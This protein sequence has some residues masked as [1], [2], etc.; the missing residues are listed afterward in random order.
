VPDGQRMTCAACGYVAYANPVPSVCAIVTDGRGRVLLARR[1]EEPARGAW[2]LPGGF[3]EEGEAPLEA[4][5]RELREETGLEVEVGSLVGVW[6]DWYGS[7]PGSHA[8][9]NLYWTARVAGGE[10]RPADDV[11]ELRW[12]DAGALPPDDELA[13]PN[14]AEALR[15]WARAGRVS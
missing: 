3:V 12:F 13:F 10:P 9:L 6:S 8:T 7:G 5:R 1:A 4:L 11:S 15:A 2:D 14:V